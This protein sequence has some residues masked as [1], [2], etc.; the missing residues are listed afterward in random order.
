M[1]I[2]V[3]LMLAC[4]PQ[5]PED[6]RGTAPG[7]PTTPTP[8]TTDSGGAVSCD[9]GPA[10]PD[11][12]AG[13]LSPDQVTSSPY[14]FEAGIGDI[15]DAAP[16]SGALGIDITVTDAVVANFT[17][18][19]GSIDQLWLADSAGG[20]QT[21][22]VDINLTADDISPGDRVS[23]IA[24]EITTYFGLPELTGLSGL[25]VTDKDGAVSVVDG[26]TTAVTL[27]EHLNENIRGYGTLVSTPEGCGGSSVCADFSFGENTVVLR[28]AEAL[29]LAEGDCVDVLA[30]LGIYSYSEQINIDNNDWVSVY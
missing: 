1:R 26:N 17:E 14:D 20:L 10:F 2:L 23:F 3:A 21:Y 7:D 27:E 15:L 22:G 25:T 6:V 9:D 30:P 11:A 5:E 18:Y 4:V 28:F 19:G 16:E 12:W 24:T 8:I 13:A 29:G